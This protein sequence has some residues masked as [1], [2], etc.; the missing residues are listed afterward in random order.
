MPGSGKTRDAELPDPLATAPSM[1]A[2]PGGPTS[3]ASGYPQAP[4]KPTWPAETGLD[5]PTPF[6]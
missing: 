6:Q 1:G 3:I 4:P 2:N 5:T